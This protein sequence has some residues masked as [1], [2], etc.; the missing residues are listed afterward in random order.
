MYVLV[1]LLFSSLFPLVTNLMRTMKASL[2]SLLS[3]A[4][5]ANTELGQ[6]VDACPGYNATNIS[7]VG[8]GFNAD[9]VLA[10]P[11]CNVYGPDLK[12]L[13]LSVSYETGKQLSGSYRDLP[14]NNITRQSHSY[15]DY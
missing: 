7:N 4:A 1:S 3:V 12:K 15:E 9:L 5:V 2:I 13:T 8:N 14:L 11:A 6:N 10:G